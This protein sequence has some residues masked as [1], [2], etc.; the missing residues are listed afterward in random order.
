MK[1]ALNLIFLLRF[2][3]IIISIIDYI[4]YNNVLRNLLRFIMLLNSKHGWENLDYY[5]LSSYHL[6][7]FSAFSVSITYYL[8]A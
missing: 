6:R 5:V 8:I 7:G 1:N 2:W 3:I 4:L